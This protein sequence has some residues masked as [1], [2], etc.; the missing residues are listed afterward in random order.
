MLV[1]FPMSWNWLARLSSWILV[2][3][4]FAAVPDQ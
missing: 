2:P 4:M 3:I 1:D